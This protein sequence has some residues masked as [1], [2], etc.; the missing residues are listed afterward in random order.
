MSEMK[1]EDYSMKKRRNLKV[2][3]SKN[4]RLIYYEM[5]YLENIM[6]N[7]LGVYFALLDIQS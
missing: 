3:D 2:A 6:T 4:N 5:W 1:I 7:F